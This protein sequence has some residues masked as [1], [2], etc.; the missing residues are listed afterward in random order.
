MKKIYKYLLKNMRD[1]DVTF[2]NRNN[3]NMT[4]SGRVVDE[5]LHSAHVPGIA[6]NLAA[7]FE[8]LEI[9]I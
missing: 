7:V 8:T 5:R 2:A 4:N 9:P 6:S 3:F 1:S